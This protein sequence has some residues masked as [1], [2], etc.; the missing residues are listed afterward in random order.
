L[1]PS[2]RHAGSIGECMANVNNCE[3]AFLDTSQ[4]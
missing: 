2:D 4:L 1:T 3:G